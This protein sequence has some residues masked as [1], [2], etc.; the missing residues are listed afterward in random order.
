MP[1]E[2]ERRKRAWTLIV[3]VIVMAL[4][5]AAYILLCL[6]YSMSHDFHKLLYLIYAYKTCA[7]P[8]F[9]LTAVLFWKSIQLL[10]LSKAKA[11][12]SGMLKPMYLWTILF[13]NLI[14]VLTDFLGLFHMLWFANKDF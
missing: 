7:V 2:V 11:S 10:K 5:F 9:M 3:L 13:L 1:G 12:E 6:H 14:L 8:F 4:I